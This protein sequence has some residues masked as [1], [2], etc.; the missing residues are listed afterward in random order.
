MGVFRLRKF[1]PDDP[2]IFRSA[3][4]QIVLLKGNAPARTIQFYEFLASWQRDIRN[5]AEE[6]QGK[7][8]DA[9]QVRVLAR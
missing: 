5:T 6:Y 8:I 3:G 7:P 9:D 2:L 1:M 4:A